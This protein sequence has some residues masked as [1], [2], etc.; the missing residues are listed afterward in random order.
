MDQPTQ[1][2]KLIT[3][4]FLLIL[5]VATRYHHFGSLLH[6]PDASWAI[7]FAAGFV[8]QGGLYLALFLA[9]AGGIDY[10]AIT[11]GGTESYC[12]TAAYPFL[13]IAYGALWWGGRWYHSQHRN[14]WRTLLPLTGAVLVSVT[15]AFAVSNATF[16]VFSGKFGEWSALQYL[17]SVIRYLPQ[18]LMT[19][20]G[21]LVGFG[22]FAVLYHW[23]VRTAF[24][25]GPHAT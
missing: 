10:F 5:M 20:V 6:L 21:Y 22:I 2:E 16:F 23:L 15:V 24:H 12:I 11:Q 4:L 25:K 3:G 19:T 1:T 14:H 7:F 9:A 18:F 17:S 13:I 8:L